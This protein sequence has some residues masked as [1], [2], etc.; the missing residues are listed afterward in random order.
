[1]PPPLLITLDGPLG[2]G[3]TTV[4]KIV[5]QRLKIPFL[6]TGIV[7]RGVATLF[8]SSLPEKENDI[9]R[10]IQG[11][12]F[13]LVEKEL[14]FFFVLDGKTLSPEEIQG[15]EI[16]KVASTI[17]RYPRLRE[18][19]LPLQRSAFTEK[20]LIAE[21]RDTGTV[22]FPEADLKVFLDASQKVRY[23]RRRKETNLP[24]KDEE[25]L[26][27]DTSDREREVAPLTIPDPRYYL[28][29]THLSVDEVVEILIQ[30]VDSLKQKKHDPN[31]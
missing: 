24:L 26:L 14:T 1:M 10:T 4:G 11:H 9:L 20:G 2:S 6:S 17:A 21:G 31:R 12:T 30:W 3:K 19:L 16:G 27:R 15:E 13:H 22:V 25:L 8:L 23:E 7:Y 28:D 18:I 29:T 5:S